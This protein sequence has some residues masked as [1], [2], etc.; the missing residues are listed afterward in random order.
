MMNQ[1]L[2][3]LKNWF[4]A[5]NGVRYGTFTVEDG[6]IDLPFLQPGQ[7]FRII[8]SVFN[9]GVYSYPASTLKEETFSGAV[10]ALAIPAEVVDLANEIAQWQEKN[11]NA[12]SSP[13]QSES[14][15]GYSYTKKPGDETGWSGAFSDR[16]KQWRKL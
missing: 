10:C 13:F 6:G 1:V 4:V 9:D 11:S 15:E 14:Y 5:P 3:H 2:K 12:V 7:Y 8:G 16:L